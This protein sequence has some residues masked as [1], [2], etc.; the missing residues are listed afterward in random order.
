MATQ[1]LKSKRSCTE[2]QK[3]ACRFQSPKLS[4]WVSLVKNARWEGNED[5]IPEM[6]RNKLIGGW[7]ENMGD[8]DQWEYFKDVRETESYMG[9][10]I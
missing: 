10:R 7:Q 5:N 6:T 4:N 3:D 1:S 9:C 8:E 2:E